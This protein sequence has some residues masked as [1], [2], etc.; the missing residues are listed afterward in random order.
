M[1]PY[2]LTLL[3]TVVAAL[4]LPSIADAQPRDRP[5]RRQERLHERIQDLRKVKLLDLLDLEG[6]QVEKFFAIYNKYEDKIADA[7]KQIDDAARELQG[8]IGNDASEAELGKLTSELRDRIRAMEQLIEQRFDDS[9]KVLTPR[10]YAQYV[11]FEARFRDEL[12]RMILDRMRRM[13]G[14]D[15]R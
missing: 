9:R 5:E 7:K 3:L 11:V 1:R 2:L 8:A 6:D 4:A 10:Q 15:R 13:R 12:Q 14:D